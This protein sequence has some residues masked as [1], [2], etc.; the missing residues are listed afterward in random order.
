M[1]SGSHSLSGRRKFTWFLTCIMLQVMIVAHHS[2]HTHSR[3]ASS[4]YIKCFSTFYCGWQSNGC[5]PNLI[6][7]GS[8]SLSFCR[9]FTWFL[10]CIML[11]VRIV[12]PHSLCGVWSRTHQ[13]DT[14]HYVAPYYLSPSSK[15][16][17]TPVLAGS[18]I[19][20]FVL[21]CS[22]LLNHSF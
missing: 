12:A 6:Y 16:Q 18:F 2:L 15:F 10:T 5:N 7:A 20:Q 14:F 21:R 17:L 13:V 4:I 19:L 3:L 1:Y 9:K 11:Q 22:L 8:H